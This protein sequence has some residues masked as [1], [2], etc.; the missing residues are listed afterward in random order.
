[1]D[2]KL[3]SDDDVERVRRAHLNDLENILPF[4]V[5]AFLYVSTNPS[6]TS[7]LLAFRIFTMARFAHTLVYAVFV[8]RQPA[9]AIA[10]LIGMAVNIYLSVSVI[11]AS[12]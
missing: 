10:F 6:L 9:R 7:A 11:L 3:K 2:G 12:W 5:I 1:M 8:V 4:L